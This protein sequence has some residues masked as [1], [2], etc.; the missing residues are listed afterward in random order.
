MSMPTYVQVHGV[1]QNPTQKTSWSPFGPATPNLVI[2]DYSDFTT[3][4]TAFANGQIDITDWPIQA[5]DRSNFCNNADIWCSAQDPEFGIFQL[6]VNN[7]APFLGKAMQTARPSLVGSVANVVSGTSSACATGN[8]QLTLNVVNI[9]NNTQPFK[10]SLNAITIINQPSGTPSTFANDLGGSAPTGSYRFQCILAGVYQLSGTMITGNSTSGTHLG[11]G[12][13]AGCT[14]VVPA[15]TG[16][17][18]G[19]VSASWNVVWNSPGTLTPTAAMPNIMKA[20][21]HLVDKPEFVQHDSVLNG[22]ATCDDTF[23]APA[24]LIQGSPCVTPAVG[25]PGSPFPSS[26]LTRE[27]S[28]LVLDA[29]ITSCNPI[30]AYNLVDDNIGSGSVWWGVPG[31]SA[32][33]GVASGYSG[34]PDIDA[35]CQYLIAAG[36]ALSGGTSN[37]C[38]AFAQ[39]SVGTT[40]PT[41]YPR[42]TAPP[43]THFVVLLRTDPPRAHFGQIISDSINLLFGTPNDSGTCPAPCSQTSSG[44]AAVLYFNQAS[45]L[46]PTAAYASIGVA[47]T[48]VFGDGGSGRADGWN[49]YTGGFS[50]GSTPDFLFSNYHSQFGSSDCG[51]SLNNFPSNYVFHCDP[52][53]DA[54]TSAGEFQAI[55][56]PTLTSA[57]AIFQD[58]A[59]RAYNFPIGVVM[60]SR[61]QQFAALNGW[62]W[63][64]TGGGQGSS[65]VVQKGHGTQTGFWSLLNARQLPG[66]TPASSVYTPG[67][68]NPNLIRRGFSQDPDTL[69]PYQ[70]LTVWDFE[71]IGQVFDTLL[72]VN[73]ETGGASQQVI[74]WMTTSHSASFNP[75]ELGCIPPPSVS[76]PMCVKGIVTQTWHLRDDIFFHDNTPVT[77]QDVVYSILTTRDD[78][79]AN[80]FS[81]AAFVTNAAAIDSKT[82][83]V[84]LQSNSPY[85]ELNIGSILIIPQHL[86][87][88]VCGRISPVSTPGGVVSAVT[89]GPA[90]SCADPS[91]DPLTCTG[92]FGPVASCGTPFPDGS[93]QGIFVGSGDWTCNNADNGKLAFGRPGGSCVQ[94]AAG[95]VIGGGSF[96]PD[97]RVLLQANSNY[98]RGIRGG[99]AN[100]LQK[101][102]W[103]DFNDDGVVNILDA[104]NA[105]FSFDKANSYWTHPRYACSPT[106]TIVDICVMSALSV[107]FDQGLTAPFGGINANPSTQLNVLDPQIDAYAMQL[108][109]TSTC[110]YYRTTTAVQT[111][112]EA[113]TC[114]SSGGTSL[115]AGHVIASKAFPVATSGTLGTPTTGSVVVT[116]NGNGISSWT[117]TLASGSQYEI[118]FYDNGVQIG[119]FYATL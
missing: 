49:L 108:S 36:F 28:N 15:G 100:S 22:G 33:G 63:Q 92:T 91:F 6:D 37:T 118:I 51:G 55:S 10:D 81:S 50:L 44:T 110:L 67:G 78:P 106:A 12:V 61:I 80:A 76:T 82:V 98:M 104:S 74:D 17:Q 62:N 99:Q 119:Q 3:M 26:V 93:L 41:S 27:C 116:S 87:G 24:H 8:G 66:Y 54:M 14:V 21:A 35:A 48:V 112:F 96:A 111:Q 43:G 69:N 113:L 38:V 65:I 20:I 53:F 46:Q 75:N 102:S 73:P 97:S 94:S 79:S 115:P 64:Q 86:W 57:A 40:Q 105:A 60:Y 71:V 1:T 23:L 107:F 18:G 56:S 83:Q 7:H 5:P 90:S 109:G 58:A 95:T 84:K 117:P 30:S 34:P 89:N 11:C 45:T 70:A 103:A 68:G 19:T 101:Q 25:Q 31:R 47:V 114:G 32:I 13:I 59:L 4:F 39:A 29:V 88:S 42:F 52:A 16:T 2:H 72:Q 9:E 85:Y 77:A